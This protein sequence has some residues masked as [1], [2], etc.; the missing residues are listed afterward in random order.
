MADLSAE[1]FLQ[2]TLDL[3]LI[4][5]HE[6]D[7]VWRELGSAN[8]PSVD[9][10][11]QVLLGKEFMTNFQIDRLRKGERYGY[12]YGKYKV[13]YGVGAGTFARVYR[14]EHVDTGKVYAV[15]VL[16]RRYSDDMDTTEQFLR[17][18][19]LVMKLRH[20]HVVPIFEVDEDRH[21][22][23]MVMEFVEG[24]NLRDFIKTR[25]GGHMELI[26]SLKL[27]V[28]ITSGLEYALSQGLT[29][30][31]MKLS[32]V[33]VTSHGSAKLV[34]FGLAAFS[35]REQAKADMGTPRSIDYA[36]LER[37]TRVKNGDP[38]SDLYFAGC[39]L[40]HLL[41]GKS[42]LVETKDRAKR[43]SVSRFRD[44][45]PITEYMPDLPVPVITLIGK[46]MEMDP[47]KRYG[48]PTEL[49][50]ELRN[51]LRRIEEG[52]VLDE[53]AAGENGKQES[54]EPKKQVESREGDSYTVMVV[55]S[56]A[57]MQDFFREQLKKRG[58]RVL[59]IS[60]PERA[61]ERFVDA[62]NKV[63]DC[64]IFCAQVLAESALEAYNEFSTSDQT[65]MVPA[66][67][68]VDRQQQSL[69]AEATKDAQHILLPS[70]L[71][72]RALRAHLH[73]LIKAAE[74]TEES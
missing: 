54:E 62:T 55:E 37:S 74:A 66:I 59:I 44:I 34:D 52:D 32:N 36:G 33:L 43:L 31:D 51:V 10:V 73:K 11:I 57:E 25:P 68:V 35:D 20:P 46:A 48:S 5:S 42:P 71:K 6:V 28:D 53:Q 30:R 56:K 1:R 8:E 64:V 16:R 39:M 47:N 45:K 29:H 7:L 38:R 40:Y 58:Y 60:S 13:L 23:F 17:E 21:R 63:A 15:K 14:A 70:D 41:S 3:G 69:I 12:F 27:L 72:V 61:M 2:R 18:A 24:N 67:L 22:Q 26:E 9:E 4:G 49:H 19:K 65:K 50:H